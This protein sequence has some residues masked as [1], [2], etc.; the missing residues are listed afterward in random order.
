MSQLQP[1]VAEIRPKNLTIHNHTRT[2]NYYWLREKHNPD[3]IAYLEAENAYTEAMTAHTADLR[4]KLYA[5]MVGRIQ[6]T[7]DTV[8]ARKGAYFYY[9]RTEEGK[10][11][12][13]YCRKHGSLDAPEEILLDMNIFGDQHDYVVLGIYEASPDHNLLAYGLDTTGAETYTIR[14]KNLQTGELLNDVIEQAAGSAEWGDDNTFYYTTE[15]DAKRADK[16]WRH[17]LGTQQTDDILIIHEPDALYR[18]FPYKT[19]DERYLMV[20]LYGI[21]TQE[22]QFIDLAQPNGAL[23]PIQP[24]IAGM[25][26]TVDHRDGLFYIVTNADE[27]PNNKVVTVSADNPAKANWR[28]WLPHRDDV[29][30]DAIDLFAGHMALTERANGLRQLR[31]FDFDSTETHTISFPEPVYTVTVN[32]NPEYNTTLLRFTYM[33]LTTPDSVYDYDMDSRDRELKKRKPVLGGYEPDDYQSERIFAT[34]PDGKQVPISIVYRKGARDNGPASLHLYGYGSYGYTIDP[35]F[36]SNRLS[37]LDRGV[38]FAIAHVRGSQVMGRQWYDEGK[39]LSKKNTFT[40]FIACA[41]HLIANRYTT[42]QQMTMEGRSAGGLLMGAVL[43]MAPHLFKG[44]VAGVPFV[45]VVTTML[46]ESI[47]LTVGEFDEWG[48]PKD[49]TYYDYMLSYSPYDNVEAKDYHN[50]LVTAGLN[51]PRV[52][53]WE[54]AKWVA[55]LR[56]LKTDDNV[57]IMKMHMGAGHFSSS[58]RYDYLKDVAFDYA[59]ILDMLVLAHRKY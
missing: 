25:R 14:V 55:K 40:D 50:I 24:R 30:L 45:D 53:Y 37:L 32:R 48:N 4:D 6:E 59:F 29:K 41:E 27:S 20:K 17:T 10:Q 22:T 5:E 42:P 3:V 11:Y 21:E 36:N 58:G 35:T 2:D 19:R 38:I 7:D 18:V 51:D 9:S 54:P 23:V 46:D 16:M 33:S 15:D 26:Y 31:I 1:P 52:Q 28:D 8:P 34:A 12:R 43:N 44:A 47:P 13:I 39:F 49:K 56:T 57:L